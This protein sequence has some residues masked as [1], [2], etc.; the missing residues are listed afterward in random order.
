MRDAPAAVKILENLKSLGAGLS[1]D[2]FGTG[3]SSLSY[4]KRF[5]VD[6]LK[7][8]RS[9]VDGLG[10]DPEDSAIVRAIISLAGALNLTTVAEGVET[11]VQLQNLIDLEC[12]FAQGYYFARPAPAADVDDLLDQGIL[13]LAGAQ[14]ERPN[15]PT[16][17]LVE[18]RNLNDSEGPRDMR[19]LSGLRTRTEWDTYTNR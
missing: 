18:D 4:L 16:N 8:D 15:D 13:L 14:V 19:H 9:F 11:L 5:P 12:H 10:V 3:Y 17:D 6:V 1:V 7:I 2:D